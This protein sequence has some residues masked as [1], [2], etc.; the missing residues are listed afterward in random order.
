MNQQHNT[1]I[2]F[3]QGYEDHGGPFQ[4]QLYFKVN[5]VPYESFPVFIWSLKKNTT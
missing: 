1:E 2:I 3:L 4:I 5:Q